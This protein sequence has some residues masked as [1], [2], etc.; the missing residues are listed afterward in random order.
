MAVKVGDDNDNTL[1][2]TSGIDTLFG[3]GGDD[4]LKGGGGD[5]A[6]LGGTGDDLM[7]GGTGNDV[8]VVDHWVDVDSAPRDEVVEYA[9]Q[10]ID[11]VESYAFRYT[12]PDHVENL[13][14]LG[15]AEWGWGNS[16]NNIIIGN[17]EDNWIIGGEGA[18]HMEG[19]L[20]N[21]LYSVDSEL[22]VVIEGVDA[23]IDGVGST[24]EFTLSAN[25]ENLTL[26]GTADIDGFGNSKDNDLYGNEGV[27]HL[28]GYGGKDFFYGFGG[29]DWFYGGTG[30]DQYYVS[31]AGEHVVENSGGGTDYVESSADYTLP[32]HVEI[33]Q[34]AHTSSA[35]AGTGNDQ[36]NW[37]YG[38]GNNNII[39]GKGGDDVLDGDYGNDTLKG[40]AGTDTMTGGFGA[41]TFVFVSVAEQIG[42]LDMVMDFSAVD[43]D[44]IDVN[45]IDANDLLAGN[46]DFAFIGSDSYS[47]AGQIRFGTDGVNTYIGLNTDADFSDSEVVFGISGIVSPDASW[48]VL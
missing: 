24:V 48:F 44:K 23:G 42:T 32:N 6:L 20:G 38:N 16:L 7:L 39:D 37:I 34:L 17:A 43:G 29:E 21:D 28:W 4:T 36:K 45:A 13:T 25:L 9:G 3:K 5:D 46:Q 22:D 19:G 26:W 35:I 47:A 41:D 2:G 1:I 15:T 18:D 10:G 27:N 33:L 40:G 31:W 12:L 14:L 11:K 8:Y 30:D